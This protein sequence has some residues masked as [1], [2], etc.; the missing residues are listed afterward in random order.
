MLVF[1]ITLILS[2]VFGIIAYALSMED[3]ILCVTGIISSVL[4]FLGGIATCI[5]LIA[6]I[7]SNTGTNGLVAKNQ[8]RYDSLVY[9]LENNLYDNDNDLGKK[10]LYNEI[11]EW[12]EDLAEGKELQH[13]IWVGWF[14]ANIYSD[15]EF[16]ELE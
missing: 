16:I 1:L 12:N 14:Y 3:G 6:I 9:Q 11:R 8:Q 7:I 13:D 2:I 15:F 10:E 5:M 4:A